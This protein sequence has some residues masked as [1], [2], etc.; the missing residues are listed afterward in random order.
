MIR[1]LERI[2]VMTVSDA[3]AN[4]DNSQAEFEKPPAGGFSAF[5]G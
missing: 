1:L 3:L 4:S 5:A 2:S